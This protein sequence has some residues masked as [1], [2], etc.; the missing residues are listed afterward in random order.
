MAST[1]RGLKVSYVGSA[2]QLG[3]VWP[4]NMNVENG[5]VKVNWDDGSTGLFL[6][7]EIKIIGFYN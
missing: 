2:R 7:S 5:Y 6:P 3:I 4:E 1:R